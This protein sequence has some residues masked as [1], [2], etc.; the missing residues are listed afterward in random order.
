MKKAIVYISIIFTVL[1][2][3]IAVYAD[4]PTTAEPASGTAETTTEVT[5]APPEN[6]EASTE[7]TTEVTTELTTV[8]TT[9]ATTEEVTTEESTDIHGEIV[10]TSSGKYLIQGTKQI[11]KVQ[12]AIDSISD[13]TKKEDIMKIRYM[14]NALTM[15]QKARVSNE[16]VLYEWE[17]KNNI[18]YD[19]SSLQPPDDSYVSSDSKK[20]VSYTYD[21][22][23]E[24]KSISISIKYTVDNDA[25]GK[26]DVPEI[27]LKGPDGTIISISLGMTEIKNANMAVKFT[28]TDSFMQL[29]IANCTYGRW[30]I[31]TDLPVVFSSMDY[32]GSQNDIE[33]IP[34][35]TEDTLNTEEKEKKKISASTIIRIAIFF[36]VIIGY[37]FFR[38]YKK[39]NKE[40]IKRENKRKFEQYV[41]SDEEIEKKKSELRQ[42]LESEADYKEFKDTITNPANEQQNTNS[43][44]IN[45][46]NTEY[47]NSNEEDD[48]LD[49]F[50]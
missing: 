26:Y 12:E 13:K 27:N 47:W 16:S 7:V 38:S 3:S 18:V 39:A 31:S 5:T 42:L 24:K 14:Y 17:K 22:S 21:I 49:G 1:F 30:T 41:K 46:I 43:E 4:E 6:T 8:A 48:F 44:P 28:W 32:A 19:Y 20:G 11:T 29:D 35:Y 50:N 33:S 23:E 9:E 15:A 2:G 25:D 40:N 36:L 34:E 37:F 45:V 10:N